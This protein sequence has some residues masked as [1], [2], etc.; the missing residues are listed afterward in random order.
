MITKHKDAH[1][2]WSARVC[3]WQT[4]RAGL[5][6]QSCEMYGY[7]C[8]LAEQGWALKAELWMHGFVCGWKLN[9]AVHSQKAELRTNAVLG[10][11]G[12]INYD[13]KKDTLTGTTELTPNHSCGGV[14]TQSPPLT[15]PQL[16]QPTHHTRV[17][18]FPGPSTSSILFVSGSCCNL[19]AKTASSYPGP[20]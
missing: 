14:C 7:V 4:N 18:V 12:F 6:A 17:N 16:S 19:L 3:V 20:D 8:D 10:L 2:V 15:P 13:S 11:K 1:W 9:R 5:W